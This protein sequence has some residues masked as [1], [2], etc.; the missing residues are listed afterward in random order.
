MDGCAGK[1]R[2]KLKTWAGVPQ[3]ASA[4]LHDW[5]GINTKPNIRDDTSDATVRLSAS[6]MRCVSDTIANIQFGCFQA[7]ISLHHGLQAAVQHST[8]K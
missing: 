1:C 4:L 7:A 6:M 8:D 5:P 3:P 2:G